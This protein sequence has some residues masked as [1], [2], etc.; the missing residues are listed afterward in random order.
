MDN[1][2]ERIKNQKQKFENNQTK[3]FVEF[4]IKVEFILFYFLF[5]N[6]VKLYANSQ[7]EENDNFHVQTRVNDCIKVLYKLTK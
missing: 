3:F 1:L 4:Y 6:F 5:L 7:L 2:L